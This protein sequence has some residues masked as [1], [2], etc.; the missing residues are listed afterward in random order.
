MNDKKD[1]QR[2][3]TTNIV[4]AS[5]NTEIR[6]E[7]LGRRGFL[8]KATSVAGSVAGPTLIGTGAL[9]I[10]RPAM[11]NPTHK[12]RLYAK[13]DAEFYAETR[14]AGLPDWDY[15]EVEWHNSNDALYKSGFLKLYKYNWWA[16]G[17][18]WATWSYQFGFHEVYHSHSNRKDLDPS[19]DLY[20]AAFKQD[21]FDRVPWLQFKYYDG[22]PKS[23]NRELQFDEQWGENW[24]IPESWAAEFRMWTQSRHAE[25]GFA[26]YGVFVQQWGANASAVAMRAIYVYHWE[27]RLRNGDWEARATQRRSMYLFGANVRGVWVNLA[28][29]EIEAGMRPNLRQVAFTLFSEHLRNGGQDMLEL[30]DEVFANWFTQI[31]LQPD[32]ARGALA[33]ILGQLVVGLSAGTTYYN[34]AQRAGRAFQQLRADFPATLNGEYAPNV[35]SYQ[36]IQRF[37]G[38]QNTLDHTFTLLNLGRAEY[39]HGF[40]LLDAQELGVWHPTDLIDSDS[41]SDSDES[42]YSNQQLEAANRYPA[43]IPGDL[44][45][46][47]NN[48]DTS[49]DTDNL[50]SVLTAYD[51]AISG[52]PNKRARGNRR[53]WYLDSLE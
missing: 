34:A 33:A 21:L 43:V 24:R 52:F 45:R 27:Y 23:G 1:L 18:G 48:S 29:D 42:E 11:A 44:P 3:A 13:D 51:S 17:N 12:N 4:G 16:P 40:W 49:S 46:P 39:W 47:A 19:K 6:S 14:I 8:L 35:G 28:I 30:P 5:Q 22:C 50:S 31:A 9:A 37:R 20:I 25:S 2:A 53:A 26:N 15:A 10:S 36:L 7:M 41:D 32:P 38:I